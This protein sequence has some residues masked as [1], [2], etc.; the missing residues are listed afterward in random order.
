MAV[1][2]SGIAAER[3]SPGD[4]GLQLFENAVATG[5]ALAAIILSIGPVSGAHVNPAVTLVEW[6]S[7]RLPAAEAAAY[8]GAQCI[9][10][11]VG[12]MVANGLFSLPAVGVSHHV[13]GGGALWASEVVATFGLV[14]VVTCVVRSGRSP[15]VPFAVGAYIAG[16][17]FFTPSTSFANP[18]VTLARTLTDTFAGIAPGSAAAFV[19]AQVVGAALAVGALHAL[20]P[21]TGA[22]FASPADLPAPSETGP[23]GRR[24]PLPER[25]A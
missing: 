19:V 21:A 11:A 13:R 6:V 10:G 7:G 5:A 17:Y 14:L 24:A 9:G 1:V 20:Y 16:A 8:V 3:L 15:A 12:A 22:A 2:G 4:A 25:T 23:G 18:A